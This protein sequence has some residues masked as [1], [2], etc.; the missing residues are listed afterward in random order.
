MSPRARHAALAT[1]AVLTVAAAAWV[2]VE[3]RHRDV[4]PVSDMARTGAKH[5]ADS[6]PAVAA[7]A[8]DG[9]QRT[10]FP[11][12]QADP[13]AARSWAPRV[14]EKPAAPTAPPLP[15]TY[16]GR[17]TEDGKLY[18][19]LQRGERSYTVK[20][21][22]VLDTQYRVEEITPGALVITYLPLKQRQ[23]L[24]TGSQEP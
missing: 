18:V 19:F 2:S 5:A 23:V 15:Y 17:M 16:F 14:A 20:R 12:A 11:A 4:V 13:F 21:G 7:T 10:A 3:D 9:L 24:H 22:D 8:P 6:S 1:A